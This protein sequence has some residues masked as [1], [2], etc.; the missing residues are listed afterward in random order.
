MSKSDFDVFKNF[1][2]MYLVMYN[3][4]LRRDLKKI[5]DGT[6]HIPSELWERAMDY[7]VYGN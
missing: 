1:H 4:E 5:H 2:Y 3:R 7:K 6:S